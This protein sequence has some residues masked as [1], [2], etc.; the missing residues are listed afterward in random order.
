MW[1]NVRV[2]NAI[3][4]IHLPVIMSIPSHFYY[5]HS[6]AELEVKDGDA[7][8]SLLI[9]QDCFKFSCFFPYIFEVW[10]VV[11]LRSGKNC[12]DILMD[13]CIESVYCFW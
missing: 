11:L 3:P 10:E 8:G 12:V 7:P 2:L 6:I 5:Y 9:V 1:I 4:L 13:Y